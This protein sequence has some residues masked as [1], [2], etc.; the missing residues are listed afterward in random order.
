MKKIP[1]IFAAGLLALIAA[2]GLQGQNAGVRTDLLVKPYLQLGT[3]GLQLLWHTTDRNEAWSLEVTEEHS[4]RSSTFKPEMRR[5]GGAN[6]ETHRIYYVALPH[7]AAGEKA[8]YRLL[9][10]QRPVFNASVRAPKERQ[11]AYRFAV[12]GDCAEDTTGQRAIAYQTYQAQP[13]FVFITGDIVYD[14]GRISQYRQRFFP[15][16]NADEASPTLG[17]PL[18]RSTLFVAAPGNHDILERNLERYPDGLAY[19]LYWA[20]PLNGPLE[21][22]GSPNTPT[23][24]GA[25]K[26]W[27]P[28]LEAAGKNYPRMANFSFDYANAH[29]IV[30]D[31]NS[32]VDWTDPALRAWL[33]DDLK[34]AK[35]ATWRFVGFHHPG[36]S[37]ARTHFNEQR[38]RVL[39]DIFEQGGVDVVFAGHVHNYQ[40]S[41]PLRFQPKPRAG[42]KLVSRNGRVAGTWILDRKFDGK[43]E[44]KPNGVI[45]LVTGAGGAGLYNPEQQKLSSSWQEFTAQYYAE[46]HSL[47]LADVNGSTLS[48]RQLSEDGVEVDRFS[49]TK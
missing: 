1:I 20:Q 21:R 13:D 29:W 12:F 18:L 5:V 30:L 25:K 6:V 3:E 8:D 38:M 9:E 22:V 26:N 11:E 28:F 4:S 10:G 19:F 42:K 2:T 49:L 33:S 31:S 47:T 24:K 16:Y 15:I 32:Y 40:R 14:A 37:S 36:F 44:T 7:L 45:Y 46:K 23:L 43:T 27:T 41:L 48:V 34:S 35:S 39:S 17:A